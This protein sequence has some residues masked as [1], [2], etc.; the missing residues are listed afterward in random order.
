MGSDGPDGRGVRYLAWSRAAEDDTVIT[1][2]AIM[3]RDADGT[4]R[5]EH[6]RHVTGAL[7][8]EVWL[9]ALR[10][11]GLTPKRVALEHSEVPQGSHHVFVG[12]K[13]KQAPAHA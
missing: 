1:D 3:L 7:P 9:E 4:V 12:I 10:D 2:Y 8:T 13:P 6:D 5:V 11:A